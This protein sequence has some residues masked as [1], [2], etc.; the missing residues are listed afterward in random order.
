M[1]LF[2]YVLLVLRPFRQRVCRLEFCVKD[3]TRKKLVYAYNLAYKCM[4]S[5]AEEF[6]AWKSRNDT[7]RNRETG[8]WQYRAS[9]T[10]LHLILLM[11]NI[12][13]Y[14][15]YHNFYLSFCQGFASNLST[16]CILLIKC[17]M[18]KKLSMKYNPRRRHRPHSMAY[19]VSIDEI[20]VNA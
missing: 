17:S 14:Y 16:L 11:Q 12:I 2:Y 1:L 8:S 10:S 3:T 19:N 15:D 13:L 20:C 7:L 5:R 6:M 18:K 9:T 4:A